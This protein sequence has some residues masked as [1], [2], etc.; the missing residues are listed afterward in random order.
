MAKSSPFVPEILKRF[1]EVSSNKGSTMR[2]WLPMS[3]LIFTFLVCLSAVADKGV[4]NGSYSDKINMVKEYRL[5]LNQRSN[6]VLF[7]ESA[8]EAS[9]R[10]LERCLSGSQSSCMSLARYL[11]DRRLS[12]L[13]KCVGGNVYGYTCA[14]FAD[15]EACRLFKISARECAGIKQIYP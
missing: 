9:E 2:Q 14:R 7:H 1:L 11:S 13:T 15:V 12:P 8:R 4:H 3:L 5:D 10:R 6:R